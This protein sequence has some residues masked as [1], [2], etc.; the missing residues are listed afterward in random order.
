[1]SMYPRCLTLIQ[2]CIFKNSLSLAV[3]ITFLVLI[4]QISTDTLLL[5]FQDF[6][7]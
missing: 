6:E 4:F 3:D 1:M 7:P 5:K 2:K